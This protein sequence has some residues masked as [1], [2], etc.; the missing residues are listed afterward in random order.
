MKLLLTG[1]TG[2]IGS[3]LALEARRR[4]VD[5]TVTGQVN[6]YAE[7][8]RAA[9]L[10]RAGVRLE[11]GP[12]Q[13]AAFSRRV[14][15]GR[16]T[17]IHLA[18]AQHESGV[19]DS[20][21]EEVNVTGTRTLLE[22]SREARVRRFVYG[23]T[24]GIYGSA[25]EGELDESSPP[26][27]DNI[28]GRTKLA[29]ERV[30]QE[31]GGGVETCIVRISETYGPGD[32]RL[33]KLFRAV[34]RGKFLMIGSGENRRQV[35]Y[36]DDLVRALL[37]ASGHPAASGEVFVMPGDEVLT[38]RQMVDVIA[39]VLG[40]QVPR[41]RLPMWPFLAA[42]AVFEATF[43]PLGID[44]PLHRRRLDFFRK[45]FVFS[46]DKARRVLG[47]APEVP[48][49]EGARAT[50]EWYRAAGHLGWEGK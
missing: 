27:P 37:L 45:T 41:I 24:I 23:S 7:R 16:D 39:E 42:A 13:D 9:E 34:E 25:A 49:R 44:P 1:G 18:A 38:T 33:L 2:F 6:N 35:M 31:Q 48:F 10:E 46:T 47:F 17:V 5:V 19:P 22:A 8:S 26:N 43:K 36:V 21:F 28:Y 11:V 30:V 12:L 32:F 4:E 14:V 50:A 40:R 29:A 20:Y 15:A 3:R